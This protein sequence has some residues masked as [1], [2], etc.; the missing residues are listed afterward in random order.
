VRKRTG[1]ELVENSEKIPGFQRS[2]PGQNQKPGQAGAGK[3][4]AIHPSFPFSLEKMTYQ[5]QT[6]AAM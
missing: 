4:G 6:K 5:Q 2:Q 1:E 3:P